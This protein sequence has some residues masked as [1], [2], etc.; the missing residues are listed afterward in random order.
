M[1]IV[2]VMVQD[3]PANIRSRGRTSHLRKPGS[4]R[5]L[6]HDGI[7]TRGRRSLDVVQ[8]LLTL[9]Y[10]VIVGMDD[11]EIHTQAPRSFLRR[12]RL[13]LLIVVVVV[14]EGDQETEFLHY[15]S[16]SQS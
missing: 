6:E 13:F 12:S 11:L 3:D 7:G 8:Q 10:C 14:C 4:A 5:G 2:R 16:K 1:N 15:F 9:R